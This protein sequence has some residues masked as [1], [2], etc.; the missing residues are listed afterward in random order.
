VSHN[1]A[2]DDELPVDEV[3][4]RDAYEIPTSRPDDAAPESSYGR[5]DLHVHLNGA[6]PV[7]TLR[8]ILYDEATAL[9]EGFSIDR[10]LARR[11]PSPSLGAYLEPWRV[12][13]LLPRKRENLDRL[14]LATFASFADNAVRLV[15]LRSS[16]LY[17]AGLQNCS[18]ADALT[19][20][21]EST[22][23]AA[24][25]H[26]VRRGLILTVTRGDR[27][28][29]D[30]ALLLRAYRDLGEP[31]DVVGIDLAGDEEI[32]YPPELPALFRQAKERYGLGVTIH[33]G[34]TGRGEN[35]R[36]AV[37]EFRADR[38]GHGSAAGR[39]PELMDLL[40][41]RDVCVE[42]CPI[43]NRLTG[44]LGLDEAHPLVEFERRGSPFIICSD[45]PGIHDRGLAEDHIEATREGLSTGALSQQYALARRYSFTKGD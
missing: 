19:A 22:Q 13:R 29:A 3:P 44:A 15:E 41:E 18:T 8:E 38:I 10:D 37:E 16:V 40:A 12:L 43:S 30:L 34:E 45:N 39:D 14:T 26:G 33:A 20:L 36:T 2:V 17:L 4:Y 28:A 23:I 24:A 42:V 7:S 1:Y 27:A 9:P 5:A 21:I 6:V 35:I 11:A 25:N 32:G 31:D